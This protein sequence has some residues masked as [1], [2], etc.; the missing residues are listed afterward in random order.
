MKTYTKKFINLTVY[1]LLSWGLAAPSAYSTGSDGSGAN[2]LAQEHSS[3]KIEITQE[4]ENGYSGPGTPKDRS[5]ASNNKTVYLLTTGGELNWS[6]PI[7]VAGEYE[8]VIRYSN[9]DTGALD[10][11]SIRIN[12]NY[13][14]TFTSKDTGNDGHGWNIFTETSTINLGFLST[15]TKTF[16]L[17]LDRQDGYGIEFDKITFSTNATPP[18]DGPGVPNLSSPSNGSLNVSTSPRLD[19]NSS[20]N[21]DSYQLQVSTSSGFSALAVNQ[22]GIS[23]TDWTVSGL[24]NNTQYYWRVRASGGGGT[25]EWSS[26]WSFTTVSLP[27]PG[28]PNLSSPSNGS[29][30]VSTSPRLDWNSSANADSYQ[31][32]VSTS[33]GFSPLAANQ[34]GISGTDWTVSGLQNN[35]Q[36][37]WRVRA[38]GAGGTSGWSSVWSFTTEPLPLPNAPNLLSPVNGA[39][40]LE[41]S[42]SFDWESVPFS[43]TYRLQVSTSSIFS[44]PVIDESNLSGSQYNATGLSENQTYYWRVNVTGPGGTGQWSDTFSFTTKGS[45]PPPAPSDFEVEA[46]INA[47]GE[48]TD[49]GRDQASNEQTWLLRNEGDDASWSISIPATGNYKLLIR[50]SNDDLGIG[51]DL[52][53]FINNSLKGTFTSNDTGDWGYGW[54]VFAHSPVIDLG[55][56]SAG[57]VTLKIRIDRTDGYGIELDKFAFSTSEPSFNNSF[58]ELTTP[59]KDEVIESTNLTLVWEVY[60]N[61]TTYHV[62]LSEHTDFS[63]LTFEDKMTVQTFKNV[64]GLAD[65]REYFWRVRANFSTD[66]MDVSVWSELR[67]FLIPV[68]T[69]NERESKLSE[70]ADEYNLLPAYPN[71]FNPTTTIGIRV[72]RDQFVNITLYDATGKRVRFI[73]EGVFRSNEHKAV[74]IEAYDLPSG[75]YFI[76]MQGEYFVATSNVTLLK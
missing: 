74:Q 39:T 44:S 49:I 37:Y 73:Y 22:S 40:N 59:M 18:P 25:S 30:N 76:H 58:P 54:N 23:G 60:Q 6:I 47:N 56:L 62:Q 8:V 4:G 32:Q 34:S 16:S 42:V 66:T 65:G 29:S 51:D 27:I 71:P 43:D 75:L 13:I 38:S 46:E 53:I 11:V 31:L 20:A 57:T 41:T 15:G 12:G 35:T 50:Y 26:V 10:D 2:R 63:E 9:D 67:N 45:P 19:W 48:G 36:Y 69:S 24:Q 1:L 33:S 17:K 64:S 21:A 52:S 72:K 55:N 7:E 14:D 70:I 68:G 5:N 61:A 3:Q 28:V